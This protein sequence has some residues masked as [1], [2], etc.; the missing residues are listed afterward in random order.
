M[1]FKPTHVHFMFTMSHVATKLRGTL[2]L[3]RVAQKCAGSYELVRLLYVRESKS[4]MEL[5]SL[6]CS[7]LGLH[8]LVPILY[9]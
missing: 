7:A 2:A 8:G 6:F 3:A 9:L 5:G 4:Y 1:H